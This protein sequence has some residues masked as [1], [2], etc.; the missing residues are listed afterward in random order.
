MVCV[1]LPENDDGQTDKKVCFFYYIEIDR[2]ILIILILIEDIDAFI[3]M[4][5]FTSSYGG[6][7]EMSERPLQG[8]N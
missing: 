4:Y 1:P 6:T 5:I 8:H 7:V 2:W 3:L